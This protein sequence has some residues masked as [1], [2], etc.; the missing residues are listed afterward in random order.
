MPYTD[1]QKIMD[2][3]AAIRT[4]PPCF[5]VKLEYT[6]VLHRK[7]PVFCKNRI[8]LHIFLHYARKVIDF[9]FT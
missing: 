7:P 2:M 9:I 8:V 1:I 4:E 6:R 5:I 3:G